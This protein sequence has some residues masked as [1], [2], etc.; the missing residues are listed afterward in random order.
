MA[1]A[2]KTPYFDHILEKIN[3]YVVTTPADQQHILE[4]MLQRFNETPEEQKEALIHAEEER[5]K[6]AEACE[7]KYQDHSINRRYKLER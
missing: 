3:Q 6:I 7:M 5:Q 1:K 4:K 2:E